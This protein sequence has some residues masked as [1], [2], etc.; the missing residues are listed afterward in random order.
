MATIN[1]GEIQLI[2]TTDIS[3]EW[4]VLSPKAKK[5]TWSV[6]QSGYVVQQ[7]AVGS[8]K[9][10]TGTMLV[11]KGGLAPSIGALRLNV[12]PGTG[13][14]AGLIFNFV[15]V[16][17]YSI[18]FIDRKGPKAYDLAVGEMETG[19][20]RYVQQQSFSVAPPEPLTMII[21]QQEQ[22]LGFFVDET[23][24]YSW[25]NRT[26]QRG[27]TA[28]GLYSQN[29]IDAIFEGFSA[30]LSTQATLPPKT[31]EP[32]QAPIQDPNL[33]Q[34]DES[35]KITRFLSLQKPASKTTVDFSEVFTVPL[36]SFYGG[37]YSNSK[38]NRPASS[39]PDLQKNTK[40]QLLDIRPKRW[41]REYQLVL[42]E[43]QYAQ[44]KVDR[45]E[46]QTK[47]I[48]TDLD[49]K[50]ATLTEEQIDQL[51]KALWEHKNEYRQSL[52]EL[53]DLRD[54]KGL[55]LRE[56]RT[57]GYLVQESAV[58]ES[59]KNMGY[60]FQ[61][62]GPSPTANKFEPI[63]VDP[64]ANLKD[65]ATWQKAEADLY[66]SLFNTGAILDYA[67]E[68]YLQ[69]RNQLVNFN[70]CRKIQQ[71]IAELDEDI[72]ILESNKTLV[73]PVIDSIEKEK[74][75]WVG[76]KQTL[77]NKRSPWD[78][79]AWIVGFIHP[80]PRYGFF[81]LGFSPYPISPRFADDPYFWI[82]WTRARLILNKFEAD[83][84][85]VRYFF[86]WSNEIQPPSEFAL[87]IYFP[88]IQLNYFDR[89]GFNG[90]NWIH[91][92]Q[93]V[94]PFINA[95]VS[96]CDHFI[97]KYQ[98]QI[99]ALTKRQPE[100]D[101]KIAILKQRRDDINENGLSRE[102]KNF[103]A[104]WNNPDTN[105]TGLI[106]NLIIYPDVDPLSEFLVSLDQ[107]QGAAPVK[108]YYFR[109]T[110]DGYYNQFGQRLQ[111]FLKLKEI[112]L[113]NAVAL[114]PVLD[115]DG[116]ISS[117]VIKVVKNPRVSAKDAELPI[118]KFVETY[119]IT[120]GWQG[121]GLGELSHSLNLFPGESK[122]LVIEKKTKL[123]T[124]VTETKKTEE[125]T[126]RHLTSS[127]EDN[128]QDT[129]SVEEKASAA[130][131]ERT[132]EDTSQTGSTAGTTTETDTSSF[133]WKVSAK[134][135]FIG[136]DV[137][138]EAGGGSTSAKT[139]S[140]SNNQAFSAAQS[141]SGMRASNQS[142]DI[143]KK[144]VNNAIRKTAN[145]T[146]VN[147][148][149]EFS[150]VSSQE[151]ETQTSN[152][153]VIKLENPNIGKTA[154]YNFFQVQNLYG[155]F[156]TL[157]DAKIIINSGTELV[158]GAEIN[159]MRV[160]D[161]EEF[162]KIFANSEGADHDVILA[163]II[164]RQ[165][166]KHYG[167]FLPGIT[168]GNG[169]VT[170]QDKNLINREMLEIL[171]FSGEELAKRQLTTEQLVG[172]LKVALEHLKGIPFVFHETEIMGE[173]TVTV[174]AGAYHL[175]AQIG[176]LASTEEYLEK[177]RD[178]ETERQKAL[179]DQLKKQSEARVFFPDIPDTV[180]HL[181]FNGAL[182]ANEVAKAEQQEQVAQ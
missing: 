27:S 69:E 170:V 33:T 108:T 90:S 117:E 78:F 143:L 50:Q 25:L 40:V 79:Y 113:Q 120:V 60:D 107:A 180:T 29:N 141:R 57:N 58:A 159:D 132:K 6:N 32:E 15:N 64:L 162:G 148:K 151:F 122:E 103:L 121:Y 91:L 44:R 182:D 54:R 21:Q 135:G 20:F 152:K 71:E 43:L 7:T 89:T 46:Q 138:A 156:M 133:D 66:K 101:S 19:R 8:A 95:G 31:P 85:W 48:E 166:M 72:F 114:F 35:Q 175:E 39:T 73:G 97:S 164:A 23:K 59:I 169:A 84:G 172:K 77:L 168:S 92:E 123:T 111:D 47:K 160:Y 125:E 153:E 139:S 80:A 110:S 119:R 13:G 62:M 181:N 128:L 96:V 63:V 158:E 70:D 88:E 10:G 87:A 24:L 157:T 112:L 55:S 124:K 147:N 53:N 163:A 67:K 1:E 22:G 93:L 154:N 116:G 56:I 136:F 106:T 75:L 3:K 17:N 68:Q 149:L 52:R 173:S 105:H 94:N 100:L 11:H 104:Y 179:V 161:V 4:E 49:T 118:I 145:D 34:V 146:S 171:S 51:E 28:I 36:D 109:P 41:Y 142:K 165:V 137:S 134:G 12:R 115:A 37:L 140:M 86:F 98:N 16:N 127:F 174:N 129:F 5:A 76:D 14:Q 26:L 81:S 177:R 61:I 45:K 38:L 102:R 65:D 82:L 130:A 150:S 131:E 9:N 144:N 126:K 30:I 2:P 83:L 167:D 178:I 18:L 74:A 176:L 99:D 155:T 42:E